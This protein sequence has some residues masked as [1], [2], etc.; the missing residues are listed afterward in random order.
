MNGIVK[1]II[2]IPYIYQKKTINNIKDHR[3]HIG[4]LVFKQLKGLRCIYEI[5]YFDFLF[6]LYLVLQIFNLLK[7]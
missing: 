7:C 4:W 2:H 1:Y 3:F 5:K 6:R